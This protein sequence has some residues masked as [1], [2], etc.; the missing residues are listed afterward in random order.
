MKKLFILFTV[1]IALASCKKSDIEVFD[2]KPEERL[3]QSIAEVRSALLSSP[4]GWIATLPT[5]AGGGY[6][7]YMS[8]DEN[9]NVKMMGDLNITSIGTPATSTYRLKTVLGTELIFDTFNYISLLVDPTPSVFG[10]A[11][12]TGYKSDVEFR[13]NRS[14]TDS[15]FFTGK[16]YGQPLVLVKATASQKTLY[17]GGGYKTAID[18]FKAFFTNT[19]NP[20]IEYTFGNSTLKVGMS[21]DFNNTLV[22]G[23]RINFSGIL[24]DGVSTAAGVA[25][26]AFKL[27]GADILGGGL[28]FNGITFVKI[29]WKDASTLAFYDKAGKEYI[30]KSNP[31]PLTPLYLLF[32]YNGTFKKISIGSSLPTGVNSK[33]N[34]VFQALVTRLGALSPKRTIVSISFTLTNSTTATL[35]VSPNNGTSTF[36]ANATFNYSINND[37]ITLSNPVYDGNWTARGTEYD[38]VKNFFLSGPFKIDWVSSTD[39]ANTISIGGLY[40]VADPTA[41][42]YGSL[43]L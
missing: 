7:F 5:F 11:A 17:E 32:K 37:V 2:K 24:A 19:K 22:T 15:I 38:G 43:S 21:L 9:E 29:L 25:K 14:T 39:P 12:A 40:Q 33:F 27:D 34:D 10:G 36:V 31:I 13:H 1:L 35:S 23:K 3:G 41:Y 8:F 42:Y 4:S 6:G 20:Y 16:K 18:K 28:V 26:F 30:V